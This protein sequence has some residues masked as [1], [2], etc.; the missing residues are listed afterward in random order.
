MSHA[1]YIAIGREGELINAT[2]KEENDPEE[3]LEEATSELAE[4]GESFFDVYRLEIL[5]PPAKPGRLRLEL[6]AAEKPPVQVTAQ[7][8]RAEE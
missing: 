1:L 7:A 3:S 4:A 8:V 5:A 2:V 6:S